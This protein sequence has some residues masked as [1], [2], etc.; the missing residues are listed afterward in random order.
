M[1]MMV[2]MLVLVVMKMNKVPDELKCDGGSLVL[3]VVMMVMP[4]IEPG[5]VTL[6]ICK[7]GKCSVPPCIGR[8][9]LAGPSPCH[10]VVMARMMVVMMMKMLMMIMVM[11]MIMVVTCGR[12]HSESAP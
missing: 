10:P 5:Q 12:K 2:M 7:V 1:T 6:S 11:I 8:S 9:S 3:A 4:C